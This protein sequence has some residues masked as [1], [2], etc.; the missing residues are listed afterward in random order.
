I[1]NLSI[2]AINPILIT[3][4]CCPLPY[5]GSLHKPPIPFCIPPPR[6]NLLRLQDGLLDGAGELIVAQFE[7]LSAI[8]RRNS[9]PALLDL[10]SSQGFNA[11]AALLFVVSLR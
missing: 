2:Y 3:I 5:I 11:H 7:W 10:F 1:W 4:R 6:L 9:I 8:R